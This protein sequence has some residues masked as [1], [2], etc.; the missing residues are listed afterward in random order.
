MFTAFEPSGD[1]LAAGLIAE[2]K[3][4]EPDRPIYAWGGPASEAA[5]ATLVEHT[6]EHAGVA[7]EVVSQVPQHLARLKRLRQ[8]LKQHPVDALVPVDSP[9]AN[10]SVCGTVRKH[11]PDAKVVHLVL[12]QIWGWASWRI[13]RLRRLTDRVLCLLPFEPDWL[14]ERGV[15]GVFV[16]HPMFAPETDIAPREGA[17]AAAPVFQADRGLP[18]AVLPGSRKSE[19]Q[20]NLPT[21]LQAVAEV[22]RHVALDAV[23]AARTQA[24]AERIQAGVDRAQSELGAGAV[25]RI[26][27]GQTRA[28]LRQADAALITSGTATLQAVADDTPCCAL[29]NHVRWQWELIGRWIVATR[30]FTLPNLIGVWQT[31]ERAIPEFAPHFGDPRPLAEA[32]HRLCADPDVREEQQRRFADIRAAFEGLSYADVAADELLGVL[33]GG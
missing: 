13:R 11:C 16:G 4:R 8:W 7:L 14:R 30:T 5:G 18:L 33:H 22:R 9:A 10:W 29:Y 15:Q 17:R 31:G 26:I 27:V 2:L 19:I 1:D 20:R 6:L 24:D 12:P 21:M 32:L 3:R 23:L 25:A 28:V